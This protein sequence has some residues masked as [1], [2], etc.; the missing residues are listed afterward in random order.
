MGREELGDMRV[1]FRDGIRD[2]PDH[3]ANL[4][5]GLDTHRLTYEEAME[6]AN[7]GI[8]RRHLRKVEDEVIRNHS[9]TWGW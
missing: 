7:S 5:Q 4:M 1:E 9:R 8:L 6:K 3:V 2:I